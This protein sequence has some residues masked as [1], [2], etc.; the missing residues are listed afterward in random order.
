MDKGAGK[1][2]PQPM[3]PWTWLG[4]IPGQV[5]MCIY[6]RLCSSFGTSSPTTH[7][8]PRHSWLQEARRRSK[9]Y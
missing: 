1:I 9:A 6:A 7:K 8:N 5:L 2:A 4:G 3:W